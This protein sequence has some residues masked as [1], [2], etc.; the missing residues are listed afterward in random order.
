MHSRLFVWNPLFALY[1][2]HFSKTLFLFS[3]SFPHICESKFCFRQPCIPHAMTNWHTNN[4]ICL[5]STQKFHFSLYFKFFITFYLR[6]RHIYL[7]AEDSFFSVERRT[8]LTGT[9][10]QNNTLYSINAELILQVQWI[11]T[12]SK[13]SYSQNIHQTTLT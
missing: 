11:E 5:K 7:T 1:S 12:T 8:R 4:H 2:F 6:T 3:H 13:N 10:N 9:Q